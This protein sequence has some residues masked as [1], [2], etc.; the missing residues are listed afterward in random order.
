MKTFPQPAQKTCVN[1]HCDA[2]V[3]EW[4]AF[5]SRACEQ[6]TFM[7]ANSASPGAGQG[8]MLSS[9]DPVR[10]HKAPRGSI[11]PGANAAL[12]DTASN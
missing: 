7:Q 1:E 2:I 8:A 11:N 3:P 6:A 5:C 10:R 9:T 12:N 4:S